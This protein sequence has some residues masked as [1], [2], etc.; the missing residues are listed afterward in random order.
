[1]S[2]FSVPYIFVS[3]LSLSVSIW[4]LETI[5]RLFGDRTETELRQKG[6][7]KCQ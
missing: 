5:R 1:L 3:D 4:S 6:D 7:K 2:P